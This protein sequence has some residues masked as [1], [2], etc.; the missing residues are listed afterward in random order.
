MKIRGVNVIIIIIVLILAVAIIT[1]DISRWNSGK[2]TKC[3]S[4]MELL[5]SPWAIGGEVHNWYWVC[6]ECG[7][8]IYT[9]FPH[10][11]NE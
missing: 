2:C 1:L 9:V 5:M 7:Y 4:N 11:A 10:N 8:T 6:P 3:G